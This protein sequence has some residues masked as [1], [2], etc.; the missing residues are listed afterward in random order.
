M[1]PEAA[2]IAIADGASPIG[3]TQEDEDGDGLPDSW[4]EKY[5]VD[6]PEGDDDEDGLTNIEEYELRTKPDMADS[7]EDGLSDKDEIEVHETN[8]LK[9]DADKD[10]LLDGAEIANGTDPENRDTDGD[11]Y[12][13]LK[14]I[15]GGSNPLNANSVPPAPPIDEPLFFYDFEGDE[16]DLVTDKAERG[17]D[18]DVTLSLIHI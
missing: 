13:D 17:N 14:E 7:D 3:A 5:G 18:A 6:D 8:P 4:E 15:E 12:S 11:G 16:G 2:I 1:L 10:G 9:P